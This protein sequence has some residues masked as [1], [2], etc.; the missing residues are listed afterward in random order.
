M[1]EPKQTRRSSCSV[2]LPRLH[3]QRL[4]RPDRSR[5]GARPTIAFAP[6]SRRR[7]TTIRASSRSGAPARPG[8]THN[9]R[10]DLRSLRC[11]RRCRSTSRWGV[12]TAIGIRTRHGVARSSSCDAKDSAGAS[13]ARLCWSSEGGSVLAGIEQARDRS[14]LLLPREAGPGLIRPATNGRRR[15][16]SR[17]WRIAGLHASWVSVPLPSRRGYEAAGCG[18]TG[19]RRFGSRQPRVRKGVAILDHGRRLLS[20][21]RPLTER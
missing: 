17:D 6:R 3:R 20:A 18:G 10:R 7:L 15:R 5:S 13:C 4:D 1:S 19:T 11:C 9:S 16:V 14:W 12:R 21:S 8:G 2:S